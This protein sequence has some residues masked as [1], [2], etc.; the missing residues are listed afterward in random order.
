MSPQPNILD[1][2]V[3]GRLQAEYPGW[4][5]RVRF[6]ALAACQICWQLT[7]DEKHMVPAE[8]P[9]READDLVAVRVHDEAIERALCALG[10]HMQH[11]TSKRSYKPR[12][13]GAKFPRDDP[14]PHHLYFLWSLER[15]AVL[16]KLQTIGSKDWYAWAAEMLVQHQ[17]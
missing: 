5:G 2:P 11:P 3:F 9:V 7:P 8:A 13:L 1:D 10:E 4:R 14:F 15:V 17:T 12:V 6:P 16:Y